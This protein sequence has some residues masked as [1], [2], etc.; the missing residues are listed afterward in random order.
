MVND[1][2]IIEAIEVVANPADKA[3]IDDKNVPIE[4]VKTNLEKLQTHL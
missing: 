2:N 3:I 1:T 4:P